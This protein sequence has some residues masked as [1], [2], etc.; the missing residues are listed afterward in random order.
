RERDRVEHLVLARNVPRR[1]GQHPLPGAVLGD[2]QHRV[3]LERRIDDRRA[4]QPERLDELVAELG[5]E[6]GPLEISA[7]HRARQRP[8]AL[9]PKPA[10]RERGQRG[11]ERNSA[12]WLDSEAIHY[13]YPDYPRTDE[14]S[15]ARNRRRAGLQGLRMATY[16]FK[17]IEAKWQRYWEANQT[18]R[19]PDELDY[20]KPKYYV[21]DMFPYPSGEGLH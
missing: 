14:R 12:E 7:R 5:M 18:F 20:S 17:T 21:L 13:T 8:G 4:A 3:G 19:L 11:E 1:H 2:A 16:P 15:S 9:E 10:G 6:L